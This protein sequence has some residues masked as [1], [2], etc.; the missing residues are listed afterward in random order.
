MEELIEVGLEAKDNKLN[1]LQIDIVCDDYNDGDDI[2]YE[3]YGFR[4]ETDEEFEDRVQKEEKTRIRN[5]KSQIE[6]ATQRIEEL[7]KELKKLEEQI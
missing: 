7:K 4:L 6:Y 5:H 3:I 2:E 1:N